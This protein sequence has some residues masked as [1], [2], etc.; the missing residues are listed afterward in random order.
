MPKAWFKD[1]EEVEG[2]RP[3]RPWAMGTLPLQKNIS[4]N[5]AA[6]REEIPAKERFINKLNGAGRGARLEE[7]KQRPTGVA[8]SVYMVKM[9]ETEVVAPMLFAGSCPDSGRKV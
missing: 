8:T 5:S 1:T 4:A 2:C 9:D 6:L 3:R 7:R